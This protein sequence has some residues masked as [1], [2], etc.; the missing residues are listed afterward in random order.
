MAYIKSDAIEVFPS[1]LRN[2]NVESKLTTEYNLTGLMRVAAGQDSFVHK[3][4]DDNMELVVKGYKFVIYGVQE[5][6]INNLGSPAKIYASVKV[7]AISNVLVAGDGS[8]TLDSGSPSVF[9]GLNI[10]NVDPGDG[11]LVLEKN[12]TT[13]NY[14]VPDSSKGGS[15]GGGMPKKDVADPNTIMYCTAA[16]GLLP[17]ITIIARTTSEGLPSRG[18]VRIGS[19]VFLY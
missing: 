9:N 1:S 16:Q 18:S 19:I 4:E 10:T 2:Y 12:T 11:L 6:L 7:E 15:G 14:D 8:T 3:Y 13:G 17:G 5:S